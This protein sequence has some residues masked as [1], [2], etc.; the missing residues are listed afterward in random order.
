MHA[1]IIFLNLLVPI[2]TLSLSAVAMEV[3]V[4]VDPDTLLVAIVID[5]DEELATEDELVPLE[6]LELPELLP[7]LLELLLLEDL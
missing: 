5:P 6:L 7:E 4:A 1:R 3:L 2:N